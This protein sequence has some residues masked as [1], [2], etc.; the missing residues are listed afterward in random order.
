MVLIS[1][2][3]SFS[4]SSLQAFVDCQ[5]CFELRYIEKLR[6]PAIISQPVLEREHQMD[7]GQLFHRLVQQYFVGIPPAILSENI[8]DAQTAGW[9]QA[10]LAFAPLIGLPEIRYPEHTLCASLDG[11]R[12]VAKFDL[13]CVEKG[14]RILIMDWK[15]S[16]HRP[17]STWL[18][19]RIQTRLYRWMAAHATAHLHG[20]SPVS[21]EQ[22]EMVYWFPAFPDQPERLPYSTS[23]FQADEQFLL[24]LIGD[25]CSRQAGHF[26]LTHQ[27]RRCEFCEYRSLC[28]RGVEAGQMDDEDEITQPDGPLSI[29]FDSLAEIEF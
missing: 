11:H 7:V 24:E 23:Q 9:R 26:F 10:W 22:V 17:K 25:I 13:I 21:P 20:G 3:F 19:E 2:N 27:E 5:R 29:D 1:P 15:T 4:Q 18:Q 28:G 12:L 14:E 16:Q 8:K 6:Y